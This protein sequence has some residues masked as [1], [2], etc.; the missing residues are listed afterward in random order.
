[1]Y[2]SEQLRRKSVA[3]YLL[4]MWQVED[5]L[6]AYGLDAERMGREY[7]PQFELDEERSERLKEWY[8]GLIEMMRE[9][10]VAERGHLQ[11]NRNVLIW[12]EDLHERLLRSSKYPMYSALYYKALPFI[13]ELRRKRGEGTG[14]PRGAGE[15]GKRGE[16]SGGTARHCGGRRE[17][18]EDERRNRSAL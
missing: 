17:G 16:T 15:G 7:V 6:R 5:T 3:E 13:V 10:N 11:V 18:R 2:I 9:E 4:Y 14:K 8:E 12:L 1:M